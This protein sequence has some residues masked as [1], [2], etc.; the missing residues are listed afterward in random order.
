[1]ATL[2]WALA[3]FFA[4]STAGWFRSYPTDEALV[5]TLV[6]GSI[7]GLTYLAIRTIARRWRT[8]R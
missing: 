3:L 2:R 7:L 8:A 1:M 6:V 5:R 4:A